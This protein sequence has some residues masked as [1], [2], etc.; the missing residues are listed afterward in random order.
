MMSEP[1]RVANKLFCWGGSER[2]KPT[3]VACKVSQVTETFG[4]PGRKRTGPNTD[5]AYYSPD[6]I[7]TGPNKDRT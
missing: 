5:R 6:L 2:D 7:Q 4:R 1:K 3:S